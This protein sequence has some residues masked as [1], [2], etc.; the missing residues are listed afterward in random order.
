MR[1]VLIT[2]GAGFI[3]AHVARELLRAGYD[4]RV[5]DNLTPEVHGPAAGRPAHLEQEVELQVGDVRD[6]RTVERALSG[7]DAVCHLAARVGAGPSLHEIAEYA[8]VNTLGTAV[9][10]EALARRPVE[11]LIVASSKSLYGEGHCRDPRERIVL[12]HER[13]GEQ[14]EAG[15]WEPTTLAGEPLTPAPTTEQKPASLS[16]IYALTKFE[17][18]RMCLLAGRS[19][20]FPSVA[21]R[22]FNVYG[23]QR[24][25]TALETGVVAGF[26]ARLLAGQ[27]PLVF[28]DGLQRR[29]FVSVHDV[30]RAF[31]LALEGD[32]LDGEAI[33]IASGR[34]STVLEVANKLSAALSSSLSTSGPPPE[35]TGRHRPCD[36]R[37][38]FADISAARVLLGYRPE[39]TLEAGLRELAAWLIES[40]ARTKA[41]TRPDAQELTP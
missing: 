2:G 20:G 41:A 31:R 9:L 5:L 12:P 39:V 16:S 8:S 1:R 29:D 21:L 37:H 40:G 27:S 6:A 4:V 15:Q 14:L 19:Y 17:Q 32:E 23:P 33:N 34:W 26:A 13:T 38:V 3:G 18:E 24:P 28:E 11:R 36:V 22:L 25:S 10:I 35:V 7:V 30:A